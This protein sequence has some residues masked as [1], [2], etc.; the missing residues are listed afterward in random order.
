MKR[1]TLL[2]NAAMALIQ[3]AKFIRPVDTDFMRILLDKAEYYKNQIIIDE[4]VEAEV[5]EFEGRIKEGL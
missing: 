5:T 4:K 2:Y 1:N 3:A